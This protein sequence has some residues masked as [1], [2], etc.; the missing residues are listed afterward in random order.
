MWVRSHLQEVAERP[1][2]IQGYKASALLKEGGDRCD[3]SVSASFQDGRGE[4]MWGFNTHL[5][6]TVKICVFHRV[7]VIPNDVGVVKNID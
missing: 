6:C 7:P 4:G 2:G 1:G 5:N 3:G